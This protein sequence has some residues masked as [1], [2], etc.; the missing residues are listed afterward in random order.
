MKQVKP[1]LVRVL[2]KILEMGSFPPHPATG[3]CNNFELVLGEML[4]PITGWDP[5]MLAESP[6]TR[7]RAETIFWT[8]ILFYMGV[9]KYTDDMDRDVRFP[10]EGS[11]EAYSNNPHKWEWCWLQMRHD[12]IHYLLNYIETEVPEAQ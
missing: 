2:T 7:E 3:L 8:K 4:P 6:E 12:M 9:Q 5:F 1:T 11:R 10:I